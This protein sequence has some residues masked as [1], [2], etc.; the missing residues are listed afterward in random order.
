MI[1]GVRYYAVI[2]DGFT[3]EWPSGLRRRTVIDAAGTLRDEAWTS[4]LR[5]ETTTWP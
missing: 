2:H 4:N 5:W 3:R 1:G